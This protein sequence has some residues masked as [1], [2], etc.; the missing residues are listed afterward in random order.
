MVVW[1]RALVS[2]VERRFELVRW[3]G[4]ATSVL[5]SGPLED[6]EAE[7][8]AISDGRAYWFARGQAMSA[9]VD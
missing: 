1:I 2:P 8:L 5:D 7:S 9:V 3:D 4:A 6:I